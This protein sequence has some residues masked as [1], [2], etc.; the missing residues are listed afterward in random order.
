MADDDFKFAQGPARPATPEEIAREQDIPGQ[1]NHS[2]K[3]DLHRR[4]DNDLTYVETEDIYL[5]TEDDEC[6]TTEDDFC[7]MGE[8]QASSEYPAEYDL[9]VQGTNSYRKIKIITHNEESN[10]SEIP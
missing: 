10:D 9:L 2:T 3:P 5:M 8:I 7:L 4:I 6:L 1:Y